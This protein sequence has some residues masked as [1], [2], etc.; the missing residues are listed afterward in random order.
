MSALIILLFYTT[1]PY[2]IKGT[3]LIIYGLCEVAIYS[4]ISPQIPQITELFHFIDNQSCMTKG[5]L[6]FFYLA[7]FLR[8]LKSF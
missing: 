6:L 3:I 4:G 5:R 8:K 2:T 1:N 7:S